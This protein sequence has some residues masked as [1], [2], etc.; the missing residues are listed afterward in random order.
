VF[1][2]LFIASI[3]HAVSLNHAKPTAPGDVEAA[4]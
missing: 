1:G 3:L 2:L 4:I